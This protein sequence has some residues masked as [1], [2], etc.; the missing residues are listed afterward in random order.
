MTNIDYNTI[1][2]F[3]IYLTGILECDLSETVHIFI[4]VFISTHLIQNEF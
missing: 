2:S 1:A 3:Y 4:Y